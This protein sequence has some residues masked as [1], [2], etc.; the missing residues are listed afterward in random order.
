MES[1]ETQPS[2]SDAP[3]EGKETSNVSTPKEM[4]ELK[5]TNSSF[6]EFGDR[7]EVMTR[8]QS[9]FLTL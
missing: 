7:K 8:S 9:S 6:E 3:S 1:N 5:L 4:S 2:T